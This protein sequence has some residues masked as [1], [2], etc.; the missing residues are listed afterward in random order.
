MR[1]GVACKSCAYGYFKKGAAASSACE[2]CDPE[3]RATMCAFA[4]LPS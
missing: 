3:K 2:K 4:L 1:A